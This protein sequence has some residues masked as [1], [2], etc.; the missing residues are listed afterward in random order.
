MMNLINYIKKLL[1]SQKKE[2]Q[3]QQQSQDP[4]LSLPKLVMINSN[5][6]GETTMMRECDFIQ[7]IAQVLF[8]HQII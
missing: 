4:S 2:R 8:Y 6:E 5:K 7:T 3:R 1:L